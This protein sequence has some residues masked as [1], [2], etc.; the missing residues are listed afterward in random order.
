MLWWLPVT[1]TISATTIFSVDFFQ[2]PCSEVRNGLLSLKGEKVKSLSDYCH[3]SI[4]RLEIRRAAFTH[5]PECF[6]DRP[7]SKLR[8]E[9]VDMTIFPEGLLE[10]RSLEE[11]S[12]KHS[13]ISSLPE[14]LGQLDALRRLDLR[15][16]NIS[17]LPKGLNHLK[18]ID[19]RLTE[20]KKSDQEAMRLQYPKTKIFFSSPCNCN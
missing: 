13:A 20:I 11:L 16:T 2:D 8:I 14:E 4:D 12:L 7:V 19:L 15:G 6:T 10:L 5:I 17:T 18:K 1:L 3:C 9:H